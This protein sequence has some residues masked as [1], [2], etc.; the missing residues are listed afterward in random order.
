MQWEEGKDGGGFLDRAAGH[1]RPC[2]LIRAFAAAPTW[3]PPHFPTDAGESAPKPA[4][5]WHGKCWRG[6][7]GE[8]ADSTVP[9]S[10]QLVGFGRCC[11]SEHVTIVPRARNLHLLVHPPYLDRHREPWGFLG[12]WETNCRL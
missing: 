1:P 11:L 6:A 10:Q 9:A 7:P 8:L 2:F 3:V 4:R 12:A 5:E